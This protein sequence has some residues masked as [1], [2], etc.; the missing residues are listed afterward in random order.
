[1]RNPLKVLGESYK[2][3]PCKYY[4][5]HSLLWNLCHSLIMPEALLSVRLLDSR[6]IWT[7]VSTFLANRLYRTDS[8]A[9]LSMKLL[10]PAHNRIWRKIFPLLSQRQ[11]LRLQSHFY[12]SFLTSRAEVYNNPTPLCIAYHHITPQKILLIFHYF[13][14]PHSDPHPH[15]SH[16]HNSQYFD[17]CI[18]FHVSTVFY[19]TH[20]YIC[21]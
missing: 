8:K 21:F 15:S 11:E 3:I 1:M 2:H 20:F 17:V 18:Y 12:P 19:S 6:I 13:F 16:P 7:K 9:F 5:L 4:L 14:P 10:F